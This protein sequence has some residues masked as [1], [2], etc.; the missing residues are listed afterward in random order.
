M[1]TVVPVAAK[2]LLGPDITIGKIR[3]QV[4]QYKEF[5]VVPTFHPAYL[6]RNPPAKKFVWEDLKKI[7][8]IL[9]KSA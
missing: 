7:K 2:A 3:G 1:T 5:T 8:R 9:E 4:M 6:L